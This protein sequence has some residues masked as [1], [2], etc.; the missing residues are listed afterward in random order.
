[1]EECVLTAWA[2]SHKVTERRKEREREMEKEK[3]GLVKDK[4]EFQ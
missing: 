3:D 1:M 2:L 4:C